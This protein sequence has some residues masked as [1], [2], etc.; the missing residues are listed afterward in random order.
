VIFTALHTAL[1]EGDCT[2]VSWRVENVRAVYYE[3]QGVDG[4]G[5]REECIGD[6]PGTYNLTVILPSGATQTYTATVDLIEPTA[7]QAPT[8]TLTDVPVATPTWTPSVPTDT[9]TPPTTYGVGLELDDGSSLSCTRGATCET[10]LFLTNTGSGVDSLT[11]FFTEAGAWSRQLCRL[12]GV[13]SGER[14]TLVNMG[15]GNTGVVRLQITV[16][17]T[18]ETGSMIYRLRAASEGN[19][20]GAVSGEVTVEAQVQ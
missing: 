17:D 6:H 4:H 3:T 15:P 7:T 13:C 11:L 2:T 9:P 20:G 16:P 5:E 18:A 14:I 1:E 8:P 12:D 19:A 10:E